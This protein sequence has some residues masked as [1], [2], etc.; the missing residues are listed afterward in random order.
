M[1]WAHRELGGSPIAAFIRFLKNKVPHVIA[2]SFRPPSLPALP[3][4][5]PH[6]LETV[7]PPSG[8]L[9]WAKSGCGWLQAAHLSVDR[10]RP[11]PSLVWASAGDSGVEEESSAPAWLSQR[12]TPG[13]HFAGGEPWACFAGC[14]VSVGN[15]YVCVCMCAKANIKMFG[16]CF[17]KIARSRL[18]SFAY[19]YIFFFLFCCV[20]V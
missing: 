17:R 2:T 16:E 10:V 12:P 7:L 3:S 19:M 6:Y 15:W 1:Q 5:S 13:S 20:R 11:A 9:I 8:C 14:D 18:P 4:P